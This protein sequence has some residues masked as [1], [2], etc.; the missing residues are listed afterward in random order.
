[1]AKV[2]KTSAAG[3]E[4]TVTLRAIEPIRHD[5]DDYAPG[6]TLVA[7]ETAATALILAGAATAAPAA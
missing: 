7:G 1:M 5:G 3:S 2:G 4:P 6:D